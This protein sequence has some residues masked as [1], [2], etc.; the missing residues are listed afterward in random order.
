MS[1]NAPLK[2]IRKLKLRKNKTNIERTQLTSKA[3]CC[4]V[5]CV[6]GSVSLQQKP[7]ECSKLDSWSNTCY[8]CCITGF[9]MT[10]FLTRSILNIYNPV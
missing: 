6:I 2:K 3:I 9:V 8:M 7:A 5:G 1:E 4:Y 10:S